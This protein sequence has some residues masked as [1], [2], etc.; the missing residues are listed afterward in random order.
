[1][2]QLGLLGK[3][4]N[5]QIDVFNSFILTVKLVIK[6][7]ISYYLAWLADF[8]WLLVNFYMITTTKCVNIWV[9]GKFK[10]NKNTVARSESTSSGRH[11]SGDKHTVVI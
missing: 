6:T 3:G 2:I 1:M 10:K 8:L 11:W 5:T 7:L 4:M 9:S